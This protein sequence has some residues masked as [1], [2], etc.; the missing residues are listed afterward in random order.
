MRMSAGLL[1]GSSQNARVVFLATYL[2]TPGLPPAWVLSGLIDLKKTRTVR[3]IEQVGAL[4]GHKVP[5]L[6][7]VLN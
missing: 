2:P 7:S 1:R 4:E 3:G 6:N 5:D